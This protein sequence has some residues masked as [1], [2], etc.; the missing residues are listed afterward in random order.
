MT[1]MLLSIAAAL[2]ASAPTQDRCT[3]RCSS[4]QA[5][6][7]NTCSGDTHCM[8]RCGR[9]A[10]GCFESCHPEIANPSPDPKVAPQKSPEI[11]GA[12]GE[13]TVRYCTESE[14]KHRREMMKKINNAPPGLFCKDKDGNPKICDEASK[15][16]LDAYKNKHRSGECHDEQGNVVP[17]NEGDLA[18]RA[19]QATGRRPEG[20]N[21]YSNRKPGQ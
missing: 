18:N 5:T 8:D 17:C 11:C 20:G 14:T 3:A 16:Y 4:Q 12:T 7:S 19:L 21:P 6:C 9:T 2:L 13:G 1:R 15:K 10:T